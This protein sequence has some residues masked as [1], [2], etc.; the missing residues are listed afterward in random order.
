MLDEYVSAFRTA[1]VC[2]LRDLKEHPKAGQA[3]PASSESTDS[4]PQNPAVIPPAPEPPT[5]PAEQTS[6]EAAVDVH[7]ETANFNAGGQLLKDLWAEIASKKAPT[8]ADPNSQEP[9]SD[10]TFNS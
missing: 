4:V 5:P 3:S 1:I 9:G 2:F 10:K 6:A 7:A 8:E